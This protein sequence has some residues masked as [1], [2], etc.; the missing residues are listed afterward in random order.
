MKFSPKVGDLIYIRWRDHCT[1]RAV[2][3]KPM[4]EI[5]GEPVDCETVGF[6]AVINPEAITVVGSVTREDDQDTMGAVICTRLRNCIT[7]GKI[8]K[9][10]V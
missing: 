3:W 9:R 2:G 6:V 1:V 8:I 4:E 10:F 5:E 7:H